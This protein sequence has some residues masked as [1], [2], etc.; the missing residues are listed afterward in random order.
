MNFCRVICP[1]LQVSR[2]QGFP[3]HRLLFCKSNK[4]GQGN[5]CWF[6][7]ALSCLHSE[8]VNGNTFQKGMH[9][10]QTW[11]SGLCPGSLEQS[12][13][14]CEGLENQCLKNISHLSKN[15]PELLWVSSLFRAHCPSV[16]QLLARPAASPA[17]RHWFLSSSPGAVQ[18]FVCFNTLGPVESSAW[19]KRQ[20]QL[21]TYLVSWKLK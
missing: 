5:S 11:S 1:Y 8:K 9:T 16:S 17:F 7:V 20:W 10:L 3:G 18:V 4:T 13:H 15:P 19:I 21:K 14:A 6:L 2:K 12:S